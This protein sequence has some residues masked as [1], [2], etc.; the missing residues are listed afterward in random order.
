[1][2]K[3]AGERVGAGIHALLRRVRR[4][5][6][7][8]ASVLLVL[9]V[10]TGA[11]IGLLSLAAGGIAHPRPVESPQGVEIAS[12]RAGGY[13]ATGALEGLLGRGRGLA[14][15]RRGIADIQRTS[16]AELLRMLGAAALLA[17]GLSCLNASL[18]LL[19]RGA[20]RRPEMAV[21]C[22]L[23]ATRG[24]L[25]RGLLGEG[26]VRGLAGAALGV[27]LGGAGIAVL[28]G[29]WPT[30][31]APWLDGRA[32]AGA[33]LVSVAL[34]LLTA[35]AFGLVPL[36]GARERALRAALGSG[37]RATA[38]PREG[39][40]RRH[41]TVAAVASSLTLLIGAGLLLR[42]F[43]A[44]PGSGAVPDHAADTLM[45][46]LAL[47]PGMAAPEERAAYLDQLLR[48]VA[49]V[50]GVR[51]ESLSS[52]GAW[53]GLGSEELVHAF[54]GSGGPAG[55]V[56]PVGT[57]KPVRYHAV[58]PGY[59][60]ASGIVP[61]AGR[62][63][64]AG[65]GLGA[66]GVVVINETFAHRVFP[67]QDPIGKQVQLGGMSLDGEF[68]TVVG[69]VPDARVPGLGT[70]SVPDPAL[71]LS[72]LQAPPAEVDL[73][74]RV[75]GDPLLVLPAVEHALSRL[76]PAALPRD[77]MTLA[78]RHQAH[79]APLRWL[80]GIFAALALLVALLAALGLY[81]VVSYSVERRTREMGI[82][83]A[84]GAN[85]ASVVRL[86]VGEGVRLA[87]RGALLGVA[88][89]LCLGRLLQYLFHGVRPLDPAV[90]GTSAL[91]LGAVAVL[92]S[93]RP[94]R[95]AARVDPVIAL[96]SE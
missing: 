94:A 88:G 43:G 16:L 64:A 7:F 57:V 76:R 96:R 79:R 3:G 73:A 85:A 32:P 62:E 23:G 77:P 61:V 89:A 72:A 52:P 58:A 55:K 35:V 54:T 18:L 25:L 60:R 67:W 34:P 10:G 5:G 46:R 11:G 40:L 41:L 39:Q 38:G 66:P 71:Y 37:G 22:A 83:M 20:V 12:V 65:D 8:T 81:G 53:A 29:T 93:Y 51:A 48:R 74:L 87:A 68:H 4:G 92:A 63:F 14:D 31:L 28:R 91:L 21:R 17:L 2:A 59:F 42:G 1:M 82:R 90:F 33:V 44:G 26:V 45:L 36:T 78:Q 75:A 9:G 30:G 27:A 95:A 80:A 13:T 49:A 70:G 6:R 24:R 19:A 15:A 50:P 69:V 84:V 56:L 47:P 86:V